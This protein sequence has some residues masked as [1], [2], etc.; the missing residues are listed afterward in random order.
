MGGLE[1][2]LDDEWVAV[3]PSCGVIMFGYCMAIRS[4][5]RF[6]AALHRV[7]D[8]TTTT[9]ITTPLRRT[10]A[11]LFVAPD[12]DLTLEPVVVDEE[13]EVHYDVGGMKVE[14]LKVKMAR[15]WRKREGTDGGR[16]DEGHGNDD[17]DH[18]HLHSQDEIFNYY[19]KV[20]P[21][22]TKA[23]VVVGV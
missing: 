23:P 20:P 7:R 22:P 19:C 4:N 12:M 6:K 15:R 11:V 18:H 17:D 8:T 21:S 16:D 10:S 13:E 9:T 1:V 14:D 2:R 3:P 5:D